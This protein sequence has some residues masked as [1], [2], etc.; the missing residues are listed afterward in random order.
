VIEAATDELGEEEPSGRQ[1]VIN[2]VG[3]GYEKEN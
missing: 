2:D 1:P 3:A